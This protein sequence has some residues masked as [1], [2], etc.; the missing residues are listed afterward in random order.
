MLTEAE[1]ID[2]HIQALKEA[3]D[4]CEKLIRNADPEFISPRGP[5]YKALRTALEHAEGCARQM[6]YHREDNRWLPLGFIY[7]KVMRLAQKYQ[8]RQEWLK[9]GEFIPL[10]DLSL[11]R[12]QEILDIRTNRSGP[13]ISRNPA[14]FINLKDHIPEIRRPRRLI[15]P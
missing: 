11:R 7:A 6:N 9:F 10:F 8:V 15:M 4:A 3:K 5:H 13:I 2:R 1:I 14:A 12:M